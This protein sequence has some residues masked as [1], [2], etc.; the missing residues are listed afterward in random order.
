MAGPAIS[1]KE[2][3]ALL[4]AGDAPAGLSVSGVLDFSKES[5]RTV[6]RLPRNLVVDVLKLNGQTGFELPAGL[7][8]YELNLSSTDVCRLPEDL[9]V[10]MRLDLSGCDRL[11]ALP[12]GLK[13][14][15]LNL[16]GCINL[17]MLPEQLDVWFLDLTGCWAFETWPR[18][19]TIR[20]G[21]LR[22]RGCTALTTLPPYVTRLSELNV[23]DC[24]NLRPL[25]EQLTISGGLDLARSGL[26]DE[27]S[28]PKGTAR[29]Q[30]RW[31]GIN[32]HHRIAFHPESIRVDEVLEEA[33]TERRRALLD[34]YGY[35][36]F[37]Q[38]AQAEILDR[39]A[40]PGGTR[41]LLRVKLVGDEDLV[42][43]SCFCP[44]TGRQYMI[45]VPPATPTCRHAAAWIAGFDDPNNYHPVVET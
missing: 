41:Q 34:R 44:S 39:D 14:G 13:V 33:N 29:T 2:A 1:D 18:E 3:Y 31:A 25:P 24:P 28:L 9:R 21:R 22:L 16:R 32:I 38:D 40:D 7:K 15:T 5:G 4:A 27:A 26:T 6:P 36:R 17:R 8:C 45:R 43:M 12:A 11:E 10:E 30:L 35:T 20:G 42:A 37:L 19:A 23:C